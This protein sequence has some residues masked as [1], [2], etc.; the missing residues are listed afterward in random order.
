MQTPL[1]AFRLQDINRTNIHTNMKLN[2]TLVRVLSIT[3]VLGFAAEAQA[4][5]IA[6]IGV[7]WTKRAQDRKGGKNQFVA[8]LNR[9]GSR[10]SA[11]HRNSGTNNRVQLQ[12]RNLFPRFNDSNGDLRNHLTA[13][14][15]GNVGTTDTGRSRQDWGNRTRIDLE[16]FCTIGGGVRGV[17]FLNNPFSAVT[18]NQIQFHTLGHEVGHNYTCGHAQGNTMQ[19]T[20]RNSL[21]GTRRTSLASGGQSNSTIVDHYSNPNIRYRGARTGTS[22][23]NNASRVRSNRG[24]RASRR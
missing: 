12:A 7:G 20:S 11:Q 1:G 17:A 6:R 24:R 4:Q 19:R 22:S 8:Q 23:R 14:S 18:V 5:T 10:M 21:P 3:V 9:G 15:R 16:S 13:W 2:R